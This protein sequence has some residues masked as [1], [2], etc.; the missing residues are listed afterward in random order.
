MFE[1]VLVPESPTG[2]HNSAP[3]RHQRLHMSRTLQ[4]VT[5]G[6]CARMIGGRMSHVVM[7]GRYDHA[8]TARRVTSP[9]RSC[10]GC[11]WS[12]E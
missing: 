6:G 5:L 12:S 2:G 1:R 3:Q 11:G 9:T 7:R 10:A 8:M 4:G